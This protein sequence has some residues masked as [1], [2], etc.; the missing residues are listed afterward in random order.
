MISAIV[1][2]KNEEKNIEEC[3]LGLKWCD[4]I[5]VLDD[6]STDDTVKI[7]ERLGAKVIKHSLNENFA[8]QRNFGLE[9]ARGEWV[10]FVDA[11]ERV[12]KELAEEVK[13][14]IKDD[15]VAGFY[16]R[17]IDHFMGE[18]LRHGEI[19]HLKI[20]RLAKKGTGEWKRKVDEIWEIKGK[21][22]TFR[23][24]LLHYSHPTLSGFLT[25]INERSTLN[26]REFYDE[27]KEVTLVEWFKP[28]IKFLQNYFLRLG[29]LD[30]TQGFVFA[31]LMSL[32]SFLVRAKL[33]LLWARG[34][35]QPDLVKKGNTGSFVKIFFLVWSFFVFA[36]YVYFLLQRGLSKWSNW[37][38]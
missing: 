33:Y 9:K 25:S 11:D 32:H 19:G 10:F 12:G 15:D 7:A 4:E 34:E 20:L 22:K 30:G 3:L 17:R 31:V 26:A 2:A 21:T 1:L 6:N 29:F 35:E 24:P 37:Q 36:S 23:S 38:F 8:A 5:I 13:E 14:A 16:F 27:G 28:K 18:W